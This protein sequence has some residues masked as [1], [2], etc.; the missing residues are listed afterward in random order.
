MKDSSYV[1]L[2]PGSS[3][4]CMCVFSHMMSC[5]YILSLTLINIRWRSDIA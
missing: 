3:I 1:A 4:L 2:E 5:P